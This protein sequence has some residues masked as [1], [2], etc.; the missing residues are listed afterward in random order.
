VALQ[1]LVPIRAAV[2]WWR[3]PWALAVASLLWTVAELLFGDFRP[4]LEVVDFAGVGSLL[5]L[6]EAA[7][8][9]GLVLIAAARGRTLGRVLRSLTTLRS[10]SRAI[11]QSVGSQRVSR[12]GLY[13]NW[14]GAAGRAIVLIGAV[15]ILLPPAAWG[16]AALPAVDLARTFAL[17]LPIRSGGISRAFNPNQPSHETRGISRARN[18][19]DIEFAH[20]Y[21]DQPFRDEQRQSVDVKVDLLAE[22]PVRTTP[23]VPIDDYNVDSALAALDLVS[24][25][26]PYFVFNRKAIQAS[27]GRLSA[28]LPVDKLHFAVKCNPHPEI[29]RTIAGSG[30]GFEIASTM[31]LDE[32]IS[33][34]VANTEILFSAPVKS[35]A[36]IAYA[37]KTHISTFSFDSPEELDK[38][39]LNAPGARVIVRLS[40]SERDS[41]FS[42]SDKFGTSEQSATRMMV[43]AK[44]LGLVPYGITF[45]VGSQAMRATAWSDALRHVSNVM[46]ALLLHDIRIDLINLG[47]GFPVEYQ[48]GVPT[49]E[50]IGEHIRK[51]IERLPYH[52]RI[53]AEPGR[54][55]VA[56]SATLVA[57]IIHRCQ[58]AKREWAF[59]DVGAYNGLLEVMSYQGNIRYPL[60]TH[61]EIDEP[62]VRFVVTGPTCD[63]L[64]TIDDDVLLSPQLRVGDRVYIDNVGAYSNCFAASFNGFGPPDIFVVSEY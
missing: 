22:L 1:R 23:S 38:I 62:T 34:G 58:R 20:V 57:S 63:S 27:I 39:A 31:E 32:L 16:L 10:E 53:V 4:R 35:A 64:D 46:K 40:V 37:H 8:V 55:L 3:V 15:I 56:N 45:H 54:A 42:M 11:L 18:R 21:P 26:T 12:V 47:G 59:L 17:R 6:S 51:A 24:R 48:K 9:L 41:V 60:R 33:I 28:A 30:V 14:I 43:E 61:Y 50:D 52:P 2:W 7:F 13:V 36:S 44:R 29:L 25:R 49:W 19:T 5:V